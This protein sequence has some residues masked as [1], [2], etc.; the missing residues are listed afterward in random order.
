MDRF[1]GIVRFATV[2]LTVA[3][4]TAVI[5]PQASKLAYMYRMYHTKYAPTVPQVAAGKRMC[6]KDHEQYTDA[7][8]DFAHSLAP[9]GNTD[10]FVPRLVVHCE[11]TTEISEIP[12]PLSTA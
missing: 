10:N 2:A 11:Q 12:S 3:I 4:G 5:Y 9:N 7:I 6:S 8:V 1:A